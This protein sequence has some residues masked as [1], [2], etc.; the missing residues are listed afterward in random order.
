MG[1]K[2]YQPK[3]RDG[4]YRKTTNEIRES[5]EWQIDRSIFRQPCKRVV[6]EG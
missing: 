4:A 5:G 3:N 2:K 6:R 1:V